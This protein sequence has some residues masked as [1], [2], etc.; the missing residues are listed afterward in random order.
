MERWDVYDINRIKTGKTVI[1]G[2]DPI[3][4]GEYHIV[5][6]IVV[7]SSDGRMLIQKRKENKV[8]WPGMWDISAGG[9]VTSGEDSAL[10]AERE[11]FEEIGIKHSFAGVRPRFSI[12]HKLGFADCYIITKDVDPASL[13]LQES[14]VDEVK[15]ATIDEVLEMIEDGL[16]IPYYESVIRLMFDMRDGYG[17]HRR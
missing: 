8:G 17:A 3:G 9:A 7:F 16:F 14:E 15:Y 6:M 10:G 4:E 13:K 12:S 5:A 2:V 1:R 11:L